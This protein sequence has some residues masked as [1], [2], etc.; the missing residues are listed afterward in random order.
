MCIGSTKQLDMQRLSEIN[1]AVGNKAF[2][3]LHGGSGIPPAQI[4][5]AIERG[6]TKININTEVRIAWRSGIEKAF[7]SNPN[8]VAPSKMMP[9]VIEEMQKVVEKKMMLFSERAK[10]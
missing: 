5:K 9:R 2:L 6:I 1:A 8:E 4:K 10:K 3:S 7:K